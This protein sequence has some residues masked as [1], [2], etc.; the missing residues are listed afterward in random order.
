[1]RVVVRRALRGQTGPSGGPALTDVLGTLEEWGPTTLTVR[2]EDGT[3]VVVDRR[4]I[5]SGKPVPPRATVRLRVDPEEAERRAV[6]SWPPVETER[7]GG[8]A[9]RA[10]GGFS[11]RANS[12]LLVGDPGCPWP[13]AL[14]RVEEFYARRGLPAWVQVL[15]GSEARARLEELGWVAARPGEADTAMLLGGLA[16][17]RRRMRR[18]LPDSPRSV[19]LA[20]TADAAWLADDGRARDA[21][22]ALAV[23]EGPHHRAFASVRRDGVVVAKGRGALSERSDTWLGITDVWVAP[24]DRRQGLAATVLDALLGWAAEAGATTA[25]LQ[26]RLDNTAALQLYER[27]GFFVHHSYRYLRP[28]G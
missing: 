22:A 23:L 17:V 9:L 19:H 3:A 6:D 13:E 25:Y 18:L 4:D 20:T 15:N 2:R 1:M 12:A 28:P 11:A 16:Q 27:A 21:S 7:L 8:W 5:V 26:V 14:R 24:A 10:A